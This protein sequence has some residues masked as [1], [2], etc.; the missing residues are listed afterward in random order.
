CYM[1]GVPGHN[2]NECQHQ[3]DFLQKGWLRF[4]PA[5]GKYV[6]CD[7]SSL[8]YVA[9]GDKEARWQKITRLA[10]ERGWPGAKD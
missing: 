3:K 2:S 5:K 9:E 8:P 6:C 7:G 1:C 4:D 10:Q